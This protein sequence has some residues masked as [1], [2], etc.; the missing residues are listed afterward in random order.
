MEILQVFIHVKADQ[1]EAFKAATVENARHSLQEPGV[2]RFDFFQQAD[3]PTRF[4]LIE[5]YRTKD[6]PAQHK[7]TAHYQ[8]WLE[9]VSD[10]MVTPRTRTTYHPVYPEE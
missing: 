6:A 8:K 3:D 9:T 1:V 5:A 10:M 2:S 4:T 7:Q